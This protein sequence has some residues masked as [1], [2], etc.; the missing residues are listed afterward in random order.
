VKD[1]DLIAGPCRMHGIDRRQRVVPR[2]GNALS[3]ALVGL[4]NID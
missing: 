4:A 1:N 3:R 2:A